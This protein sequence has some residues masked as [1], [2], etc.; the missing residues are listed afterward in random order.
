MSIGR[1]GAL[2]LLF[3]SDNK[4]NHVLLASS[5]LIVLNICKDQYSDS[6]RFLIEFAFGFEIGSMIDGGGEILPLKNLSL[7]WT[8]LFCKSF[9]FL[10]RNCHHSAESCGYVRISIV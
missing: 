10:S 1:N 5:D 3:S 8:S 2:P 6:L 7:N 4:I 9:T